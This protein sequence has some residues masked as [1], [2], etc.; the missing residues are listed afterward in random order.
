MMMKQIQQHMI[1]MIENDTS[2]I[3]KM[4]SET[5]DPKLVAQLKKV[6]EN[7]VVDY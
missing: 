2:I 4:I 5:T 7:C 1:K 6:K 3:D